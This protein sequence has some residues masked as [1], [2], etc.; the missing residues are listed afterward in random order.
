MAPL[1]NVVVLS[2]ATIV[3]LVY[4]MLQDSSRRDMAS[5]GIGGVVGPVMQPEVPTEG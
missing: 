2:L 3:E 5:K 4:L 1:L